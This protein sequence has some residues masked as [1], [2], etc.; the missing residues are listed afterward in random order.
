MT[1][2]TLGPV[3]CAGPAGRAGPLSSPPPLGE[4]GA[5]P[6]P[7][8]AQGAQVAL[9]VDPRVLEARHL[10]D[11]QP[12]GGGAEVEHGLDLEPVAPA[13]PLPGRLRLQ[14]EGGCVPGPECVVP[15][16]KVGVAGAVHEVHGQPEQLVAELAERGDVSAA[17]A[18]GEP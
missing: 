4:D 9:A 6:P 10:G 7:A 13:L 3:S 11:R 12:G 5:E 18:G 14:P 1:T 17:R 8:V 16:A 15:V 2:D